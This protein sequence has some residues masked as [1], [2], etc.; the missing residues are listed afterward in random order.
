VNVV[1]D[2]VRGLTIEPRAVSAIPVVFVANI[3]YK[4]FDSRFERDE[5]L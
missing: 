4:A 5:I 3:A 2:A 1:S